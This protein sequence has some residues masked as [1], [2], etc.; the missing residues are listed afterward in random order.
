[1]RP[2]AWIEPDAPLLRRVAGI[3]VVA[4]LAAVLVPVLGSNYIVTFSFQFVVWVA[5]A[6][7]WNVFSGNAGYPS[8]GHGVFFGVGIYATAAVLEHTDAGFLVAMLVAGLAAGGVALVVGLG[9]FAS[10]RFKGDLFGL[11]TLAL[12]F[13]VT[14]VVSNVAFLDGGTGVFVREHTRGLWVG[15]GIRHVFVV[16]VALAALAALVALATSRTRW[17]TALRSIRDEEAVAESLG[18]P[19]YRYK[20]LTF[21]VSGALGGLI[22]APQAVY[23]GYVEVGAVFALNVPLFVIMMTILG[24]SARWWGPAIGAAAVVVL[25]EVLLGIGSP[26]LSQIVIGVFLVVV[27]A[28]LPQGISGAFDRLRQPGRSGVRGASGVSR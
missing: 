20:V 13:V 26:E 8:F 15:G 2:R 27:I 16:G 3:V 22:G 6:L 1:M 5:L 7:S 12:A 25:R 19:T 21:A 28:V 14:T 4:A 10:P 23:L 17:G 18:V 9:V 11:V 24:G